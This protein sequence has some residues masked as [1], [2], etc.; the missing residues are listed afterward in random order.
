M[1]TTIRVFVRAAAVTA[2][3]ATA[4]CA[5]TP[6][7]SCALPET[8]NLQAAIDAAEARLAAGCENHLYSYTDRLLNIAAGDPGP[9]NR[10]AFSDFMVWTADRGILSQRQA[11]A[12]YNRYFNVKFV[13]LASD[14][15]NCSATC[16]KRRQILTDMQHELR[17]KEIGL[18]KVSDD[19]ESY[20]R[21]DNLFKEVEL[22]MEATCRACGS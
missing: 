13:T 3:L 21:A 11:Q 7:P 18:L 9:D 6:E 4:A 22:V 19:R 17:D 8:R 10:R 15:N 5:T 16:P 14:Y 1:H 12:L 2:L 20:Y